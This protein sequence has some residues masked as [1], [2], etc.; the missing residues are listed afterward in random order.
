[1]GR[2]TQSGMSHLLLGLKESYSF[3]TSLTLPILVQEMNLE[4][5]V[6][7]VGLHKQHTVWMGLALS[8]LSV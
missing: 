1:M 3:P 6:S 7:E 5:R 4:G 2:G 8:E